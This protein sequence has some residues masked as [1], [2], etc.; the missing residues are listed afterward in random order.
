MY[1]VGID[2]GGTKMNVGILD[3]E[4]NTAISKKV[5]IKDISDITVAV[6]TTLEEL[7][8]SIGITLGELASV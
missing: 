4:N 7:C 8:G 3:G 6:K 5:Y 1:R 2:I